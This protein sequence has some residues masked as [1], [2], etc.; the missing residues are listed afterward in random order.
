MPLDLFKRDFLGQL[1]RDVREHARVMFR[2]NKKKLQLVLDG[3]GT[4]DRREVFQELFR[5]RP[6]A[7]VPRHTEHL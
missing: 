1:E 5:F 2:N 4:T 6:T 7:G 3:G